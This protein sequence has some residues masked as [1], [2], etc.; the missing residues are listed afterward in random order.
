M[1]V[2]TSR[3]RRHED[4]ASPARANSQGSAP[5]VAFVLSGGASLA[6]AQV[7]ALRALLESGVTPDAVVGTS[8]GALNAAYVA[9]QP[10]AAN[11]AGL[12]D[13]WTSI[14]TKDVFGTGL[15]WSVASIVKRRGHLADP[16]ALRAL[17]RRFGPMDDL[18]DGAI[19]CHV[20]TTDLVRGRSCTWSQGPLADVLCASACI[21]GVFPPVALVDAD[22]HQSLHVDGGVLAPV[23]LQQALHLGYQMIYVLDV[24]EHD[25]A[26]KLISSKLSALTVLLRSFAVAR[27]ALS[28]VAAPVST[29][30]QVIIEVPVPKP[31][32][33]D[34][35]D[36]SR[37]AE[38]IAGSYRAVAN[39]LEVGR[40]KVFAAEA[41]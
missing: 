40:S 12:Q 9:S 28:V 5:S 34:L 38:L 21:P 16:E 30:E 7:G 31:Q 6:A 1:R 35:W 2:S 41:A 33:L 10:T 13:V 14:T 39:W 17:I 15:P 32:G 24:T 11:I 3:W 37:S 20:V 8:A 25:R 19:P 22:G 26:E 29:A 27:E 23:P 36:F 18:A 4:E